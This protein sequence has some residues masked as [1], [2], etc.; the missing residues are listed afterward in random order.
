ML[1]TGL[2]CD[3]QAWDAGKQE[4]KEAYPGSLQFNSWLQVLSETANRTWERLSTPGVTPG[5]KQFRA[6]FNELKPTYNAGFFEVFYLFMEEGVDRWATATFRKV[7]TIY[8]HLREF[9]AWSG[10]Q[11]SF[12]G[13]DAGF[14]LEFSRF[15]REKGNGPNT[16]VKAINIVVWFMNWAKENGYHSGE[17]HRRFCRLLDKADPVPNRPVYLKWEEIQALGNVSTESRKEERVVDLFCLMCFTG[18]RYA[19]LTRLKK[20]DLSDGHILVRGNGG[21]IRMLPVTS[22]AV[23]IVGKYADRYY[24]DNL[25][26]PPMHL[27]T[28]NK[29][30]R[31]LARRAGLGRM[32]PVGNGVEERVPLYDRISAAAAVN[33]FIAN[34]LELGISYEVI[35]TITGVRNDERTRKIKRELREKELD[36][37][38]L[39]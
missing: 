17:V 19:E 15:Y 14:P 24:R 38:N 37:F 3:I 21:R 27:I 4:M 26:F 36:R 34:A 8:N 20:E 18:L 10:G 6:L 35:T 1:S 32:I 29:H 7:K 12:E 2:K 11:L 16:T 25:A 39:S 5:K 13:M 9:E 33:S 30:I 31:I 28:F 23:E 22:K